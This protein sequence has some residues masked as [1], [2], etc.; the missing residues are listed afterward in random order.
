M[1]DDKK[2]QREEESALAED[3][4]TEEKAPK[5]AKGNPL[6]G[7]FKSESDIRSTARTP[8]AKVL[9]PNV[10][11]LKR[12]LDPPSPV[13]RGIAL[14]FIVAALIGAA[15]LAWYFDGVVNEPQRQEQEMA[16]NLSQDIAYDLPQLYPLMAL[17]DAAILGT[18]QE[19]GL[20][21]FEMPAKENSTVWQVIKLPA[22]V[23]AA[24]AGAIYLSGVDKVGAADA[25]RLLNGAW[26]LKV[27]RENGVNMVL[28]FAD[29]K[30]KSV[31]AAV[32]A[33]IAAEGLTDSSIEKSGE[34]ESGNT[35]TMGTITGDTGTYSWRVSAIP[36][37][38]IYAINGL[39]E[40]AVYVGVRM[41]S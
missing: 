26:D 13:R 15:F 6:S 33:A 17:D 8:D 20:S 22:G 34:D 37:S 14:M 40:D 25:A 5:R 12:P 16:D 9:Y 11:V 24:E 1:R 27:D 10:D 39:P 41:T 36:L 38:E 31:D 18:F 2:T 35:Y 7:I 3:V 32:Q 30:S 29:F 28:H 4:P 23:S 21:V 19:A